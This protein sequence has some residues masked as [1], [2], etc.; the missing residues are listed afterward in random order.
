MRGHRNEGH[1]RHAAR[2]NVRGAVRRV[3]FSPGKA[4]LH[5]IPKMHGRV[6]KVN[7]M[8]NISAIMLGRSD[9]WDTILLDLAGSSDAR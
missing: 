5:G 2:T 9:N 3:E 7:P 1:N 6:R 4:I 8:S